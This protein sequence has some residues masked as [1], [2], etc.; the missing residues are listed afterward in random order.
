MLLTSLIS[1][2]TSGVYKPRS[3]LIPIIPNHSQSSPIPI[4]PNPH[5]S[6]SFPIP[7]I[8]N[9]H[10]SQSFPIPIIPNPHHSQSFPIPIIPN[11][12]HSQSPS[13]PIIPN[14]N[15][16]QS[17]SFPIIPNPN[18]SQSQSF[19][20]PIKHHCTHFTGKHDTDKVICEGQHYTFNRKRYGT[21]LVDKSYWS[22]IV[23]AC[24]ARLFLLDR[25]Q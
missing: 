21:D 12:H 17:P 9:P 19:P 18:H 13:F 2:N 24:R 22:C 3:F 25:R 15:H 6:Q 20:I 4:I 1:R 10:H 5:H 11:P 7:I 16:S 23:R 14:P 8:P